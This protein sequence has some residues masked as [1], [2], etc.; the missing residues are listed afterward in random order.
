MRGGGGD[1]GGERGV[2]LNAALL[3]YCAAVVGGEQSRAERRREENLSEVTHGWMFIF[4]PGELSHNGT[5][6]VCVCVCVCVCHYLSES[7]G[8]VA[9]CPQHTTEFTKSAVCTERE[10]D[11]S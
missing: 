10:R 6:C 2:V 1:E 7:Q 4:R 5:G 8:D 3:F 11:Q 9:R